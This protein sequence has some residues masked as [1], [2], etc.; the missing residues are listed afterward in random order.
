M[1][2]SALDFSRFDRLV[3]NE[4]PPLIEVYFVMDWLLF[5]PARILGPL[6]CSVALRAM[7]NFSFNIM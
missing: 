3:L 4:L 1:Y 5:E 6:P 7:R 2:V